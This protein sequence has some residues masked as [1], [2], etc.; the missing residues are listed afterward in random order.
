[1]WSDSVGSSSPSSSFTE[2]SSSVVSLVVVVSS[3]DTPTSSGAVSV[4]VSSGF[5]SDES[6][7]VV[8]SE[9]EKVAFRRVITGQNSHPFSNLTFIV[10][11]S[12]KKSIHLKVGNHYQV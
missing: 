5:L 6:S 1:M 10:N 9:I 3:G 4:V 2:S 12:N 11:F 8:V 7:G